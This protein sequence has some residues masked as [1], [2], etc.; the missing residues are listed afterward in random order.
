[1]RLALCAHLH[2]AL[3]DIGKI[4]VFNDTPNVRVRPG[5]VAS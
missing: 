2:A 3:L 1:M 4:V 5:Q